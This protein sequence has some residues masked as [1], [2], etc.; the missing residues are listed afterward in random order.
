M[1]LWDAKKVTEA[2][3]EAGL[4]LN[5]PEGTTGINLLFVV[6]LDNDADAPS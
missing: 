4:G 2:R 1:W 5:I 6:K 3:T